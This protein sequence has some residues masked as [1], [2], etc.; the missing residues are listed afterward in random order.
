MTQ[1]CGYWNSAKNLKRD[2]R[3]RPFVCYKW[4][5]RVVER[6][7]AN[8]SKAQKVSD[9]GHYSILMWRVSWRRGIRYNITERS[10]NGLDSL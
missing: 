5:E 4:N 8:E 1:I 9:E 6:N 3:G 10:Q 7:E 2:G